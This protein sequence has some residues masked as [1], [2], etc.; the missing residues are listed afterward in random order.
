MQ[1]MLSKDGRED[2]EK[3][4]IFATTCNLMLRF[5]GWWLAHT[6]KIKNLKIYENIFIQTD[7][8]YR[9]P[10]FCEYDINEILKEIPY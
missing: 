9:K 6:T 5:F 10:G 3:W 7:T 4:L 8:I 2:W 1:L